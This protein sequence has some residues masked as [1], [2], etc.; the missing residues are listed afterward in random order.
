MVTSFWLAV[1]LVLGTVYVTYARS[2]G[3]SEKRVFGSGL[4]IV[5][6]IY[7]AFAFLAPDPMPWAVVEGLGVVLFGLLGFMGIRGSGWWLLVGWAIHPAWDIGLHSL[8]PGASFVPAWYAIACVAFDLLVA[9]YIAY[10]ILPGAS[11]RAI[12]RRTKGS[13]R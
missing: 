13:R 6:L 5:A 9:A 4:V 8:G 11:Q 3:H 12:D 2:R 10:A 7:V 1:G